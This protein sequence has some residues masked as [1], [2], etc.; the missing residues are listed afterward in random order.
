MNCFEKPTV[1]M[2]SRC[3]AGGGGR[4]HWAHNVETVFL[5]F[6]FERNGQLCSALRLSHSAQPEWHNHNVYFQ[7][8]FQRGFHFISFKKKKNTK[9]NKL[10]KSAWVSLQGSGFLFNGWHK[11]NICRMGEEYKFPESE[12]RQTIVRFPTA[13]FF[14]SEFVI[15]FSSYSLKKLQSQLKIQH[16]INW[17]T[18][19]Q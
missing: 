11:V 10:N 1:K 2:T 8:K 9:Q 7:Q 14:T 18:N 12:E 16:I 4:G 3:D 13:T 15:L 17:M 19:F 6:I 5:H